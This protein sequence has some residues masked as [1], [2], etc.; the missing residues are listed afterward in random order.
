M[1]VSLCWLM[2]L[3][4]VC[5]ALLIIHWWCYSPRPE[6][7]VIAATVELRLNPR[8]PYDCPACRQSAATTTAPVSPTVQPW[9]A[10]K[11]RRGA[12]K[13]VLTDGFACPTRTCAYYRITDAH[14]HALV[15]DGTHGKREPIQRFRCQA[16]NTTFSARR[17][18]PLYRL[19]T[20]AQRV[21]EVLTALAEGLD[22]AAA[23]RV[24]GHSEGTITRWLRAVSKEETKPDETSSQHRS[25]PGRCLHEFHRAG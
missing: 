24:V 25:A 11:S 5:I 8:P 12:P 17:H 2:L 14:I 3:L 10:R 16:C 7:A 6:A 13:R 4:A 22:V 19:T 20:P 1:T 18:T 15:G 23:V 9:C 21:S